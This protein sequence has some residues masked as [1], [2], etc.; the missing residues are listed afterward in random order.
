MQTIDASARHFAFPMLALF[1]GVPRFAEPVHVGR[2]NIPNIERLM[3]RFRDVLDRHWLSNDG[4]LVREFEHRIAEIAG[5]EH[6]IA[7]CNATVGLE[8]VIRALELAGEVIIPSFTFVATAHALRWQHI[9]PVFADISS[10]SYNLD[11]AQIERHIT[12]RTSGIIATHLWG[13]SCAVEELQSIADR[14]N[15]TL[16]F[17]AAHAFRCSHQGRMIG[18]FGRAEVFSFHATKFVNAAEGGAIVTNDSLLASRLRTMR[19]FGFVGYDRVDYIGT[20]GKMSELSAAMG[21]TSLES[22]EQIVAINRRNYYTYR[23]GLSSI[24]GIRISGYCE[25]EHCNYQYVVAEIRPEECGLTRDE[26]CSVLHRENVLVRKYFAPGC[27]KHKPYRALSS[28]SE[29]FLPETDRACERVLL[30]P[31]G[32]AVSVDMINDIVQ[33]VRCAVQSAPIVRNAL[34]A[35][36]WHHG[37]KS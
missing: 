25:R 18:R 6:C 15:L 20:N 34:D 11:P 33:I 17:D 31:T 9:T 16:L 7:T 26:L 23:A 32:A 2:P 14:H 5:V 37:D 24:P 4:P 8:L 27:H 1:S 22:I 29:A 12:P 13:R 30:F 28:T 19:N 21:I 10:D 36:V 3:L 35:T